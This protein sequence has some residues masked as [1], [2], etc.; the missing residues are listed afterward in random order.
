V[1]ENRSRDVNNGYAYSE[2]VS[3][4]RHL[5]HVTSEMKKKLI[6]KFI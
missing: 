2:T 6:L 1:S 5:M 4:D 3:A